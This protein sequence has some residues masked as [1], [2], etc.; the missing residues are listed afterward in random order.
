MSKDKFGDEMKVF[1]SV[2]TNLRAEKGMP[3]MAR[4]DGRSFHT[5]TKGLNRPYDK[6]LSQLMIDVTKY[7]VNETDALL[8]YT[9]SDEISLVWYLGKG[10]YGQYLF[11]GRYQKLTSVL[12]AMAT[13]Y[14]VNELQNNRIPSKKGLIPLFDCRVW[15]VP[16]LQTAYNT[17]MW[18]E[19][20]AVK[21]SITMAASEYFSHKALQ[22]VSGKKKKADLISIGKPWENMPEFFKRGTYIKKVKKLR[23]L[24]AE[25]IDRIPEKFRPTGPIFRSNVEELNISL[26]NKPFDE[27]IFDA[28][29]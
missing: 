18:R 13:G 10:S 17:F 15:Q 9:Q 1:E 2:Q 23:E 4:L 19:K 3:L 22:G 14:F 20:D 24:N 5:F 16:D 8:G 6:N 11:D 26:I 27:T 21:N 29:N 25:E 28:N 7:L 12:S